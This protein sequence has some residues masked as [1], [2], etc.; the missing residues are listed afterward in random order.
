M[1]ANSGTQVNLDKLTAV[2]ALIAESAAPRGECTDALLAAA[3]L[4]QQEW[5]KLRREFRAYLTTI[6]PRQKSPATPI[7][8]TSII[9][10]SINNLQRIACT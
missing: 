1:A 10:I 2:T 3:K 9:Y 5:A 8:F 6:H 7:P 4:K